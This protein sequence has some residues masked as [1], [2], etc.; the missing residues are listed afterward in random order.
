MQQTKS[1][2]VVAGEASESDEEEVNPIS[3]TVSGTRTNDSDVVVTGEAPESE[4]EMD[5]APVLSSLNVQHSEAGDESM[6]STEHHIPVSPVQDHKPKFNSL[7][8]R[9]L[10]ERNIAL[11]KH[12]VDT[13]THSYS[14]AAK[15]LHNI[16]LQIQKSQIIAQDVSHNMRNSTNGLLRIEDTLGIFSTCEILPDITFPETAQ[17]Q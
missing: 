3:G 8:N 14:S 10:R 9:K 11:R 7:L 5:S 6:L 4:D 15:E 13:I 16:G 2:T 17:A 1:D 12:I